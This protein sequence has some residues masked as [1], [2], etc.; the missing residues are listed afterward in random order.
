M[1]ITSS[2]TPGAF[3]SPTDRATKPRKSVCVHFGNE[4]QVESVHKYFY[5]HILRKCAA[6]D[7]L[8]NDF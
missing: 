1:T 7:A 4:S 8:K 5:L 2:D 6:S 3:T